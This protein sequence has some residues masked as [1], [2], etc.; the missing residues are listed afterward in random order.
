M[1]TDDEVLAVVIAERIIQRRRRRRERRQRIW[2]RPFLTLHIQ[3]GAY[4]N[5][6]RELE[7]EE[8]E[9]YRNFLRMSP[10]QFH[11]I[12][13]R[14]EPLL[15]RKNTNFRRAIDAPERL[16]ITLRFLAT[17]T[18]FIVYYKVQNPSRGMGRPH[19]LSMITIK[20]STFA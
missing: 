3:Q 13:S 16:S 14:V 7:E 20:K 4:H 19:Q 12:L 18:Y 6:L 8:R 9:G 5:L 17:G 15:R 10:Q 11:L 1:E 2:Q